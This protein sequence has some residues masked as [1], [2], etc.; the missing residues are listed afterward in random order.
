MGRTPLRGRRFQYNGYIIRIG[1]KSL[2]KMDLNME[3]NKRRVFAPGN[4][5]RGV[6]SPEDSVVLIMANPGRQ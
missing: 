1:D 3:V 4:R 2:V 6:V 5:N